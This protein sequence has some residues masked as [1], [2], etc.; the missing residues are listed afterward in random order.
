MGSRDLQNGLA[1]WRAAGLSRLEA[2]APRSFVECAGRV[3]KYTL[4][5]LD[6]PQVAITGLHESKQQQEHSRGSIRPGN[7][8]SGKRQHRYRKKPPTFRS[9]IKADQVSQE[10]KHNG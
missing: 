8:E 9:G 1:D 4:S 6:P 10:L 5:V 3:D 7:E 2:S